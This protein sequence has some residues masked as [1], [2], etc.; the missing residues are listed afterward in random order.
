MKYFIPNFFL[1][2]VP[3]SEHFQVGLHRLRTFLRALPSPPNNSTAL[4]QS[5]E[6]L[7][8]PAMHSPRNLDAIASPAEHF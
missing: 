5:A 1:S 3:D 2:D 8:Q 6:H 4:V 7:G